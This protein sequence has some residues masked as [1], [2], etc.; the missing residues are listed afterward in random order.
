[1]ADVFLSYARANVGKARRISDALHHSGFSVWFDEHLPAHRAYSE[2]IEE[3]L[4]AARAVLVLWS[5]DAVQSQWVRS[6]A[7]RARETGRLVQARLDDCRLP[8]PFDQIQCVDLG[9]W[10][11]GDS[12]AWR[13]V[14]ESIAALAAESA[15]EPRDA[16]PQTA[17][18]DRRKVLL[19]GG[20]AVAVAAIGAAGWKAF[21]KPKISPEAQLLIQKGLDALQQNDAL[22]TNDAGSTQQAIA[23]LSDA[24][25][26]AP[27]AAI[28]WGGLAMAYAVRKRAAPAAER[29]GLDARSRSAALTALKLDENEPRALGALRLLDPVYR[30]WVTAERADREALARNPKLPILIFILSDMLGDVGRWKEAAALSQRL[31]RKRFLIPGAD[32]KVIVNQWSA[33]NLQAADDALEVAVS[34]WPDHPQI[35]RT[36]LSFLMYTGRATE[37]LDLLRNPS[38]LPPQLSAEF[39]NVIRTTAE[40]LAGRAPAGA[41]VSANIDFSQITPRAAL[42]IA[43]AIVALGQPDTAL[44]M[45]NGY[46]FQEGEFTSLAPPGGDQDRVTGPLFQP[47][48]RGLWS[49]RRFDILLERIGLTQYWR[50][51]GTRPDYRVSQ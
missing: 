43:Q 8:M 27:D 44:A 29:P 9:G 13:S 7:N 25:R 33:G 39:V 2:V 5:A 47:P 38:A 50:Q 49:D 41:A 37:T 40:A 17:G 46:Y 32:R 20:S 42:Q 35:W 6:E 1:M 31:D 48:M 28:A 26:A 3:Q 30:H 12:A 34:H 19:A 23:L 45:L 15:A 10:R 11:S 21:N 24:T 4:G 14:S 51:S 16:Y 22:D 18:L 36:R